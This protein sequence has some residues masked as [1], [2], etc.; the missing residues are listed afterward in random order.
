MPWVY[1]VL[2]VVA[3]IAQELIT[4]FVPAAFSESRQ[5]EQLVNR[6]VC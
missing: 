2:V 3:K 5:T 1:R 6:N 4:L